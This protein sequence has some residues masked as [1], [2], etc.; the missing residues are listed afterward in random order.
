MVPWE[1]EQEAQ[2]TMIHILANSQGTVRRERL[3]L[4]GREGRE[5]TV[6]EASLQKSDIY[7]KRG[8]KGK[9]PG[10]AQWSS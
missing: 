5:K 6:Q 1:M 9:S 2:P 4:P 8:E 10:F 3:M 7:T